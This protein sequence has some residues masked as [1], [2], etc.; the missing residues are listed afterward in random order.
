MI[1]V[2]PA[3][4]LWLVTAWRA[5]AAWRHSSKR[6]LWIAFLALA[7]AITLRVPSVAAPI[8]RSSCIPVTTVS[9]EIT[10]R[11]QV[12]DLSTV[13]PRYDTHRKALI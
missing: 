10:F 6:V 5:P 3:V 11:P 4:L 7:V 8:G 13:T 2:L 12:I 9:Q 1:D